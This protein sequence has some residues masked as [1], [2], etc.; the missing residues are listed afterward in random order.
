MLARCRCAL[1]THLEWSCTA[2]K[3]VEGSL[4][5]RSRSKI[6]KAEVERILRGAMAVGFAPTRIEVEG[7]KLVLYGS[8]PSLEEPASAL[9]LWRRK[10]GSD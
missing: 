6:T 5:R 9:D 8:E 3:A 4:M 10:V 1:G 7:G 2:S